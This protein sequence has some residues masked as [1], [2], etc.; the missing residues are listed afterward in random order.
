ME[1]KKTEN[2]VER[3]GTE[4]KERGAGDRSM[5]IEKG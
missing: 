5:A 1:G 4:E 2:R 3:K